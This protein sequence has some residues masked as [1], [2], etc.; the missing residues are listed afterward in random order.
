MVRVALL[1][2]GAIVSV[3]YAAP[4]DLQE[5]TPGHPPGQKDVVSPFGVTTTVP[6]SMRLTTP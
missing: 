2:I 1:V 6:V 5:R 4:I 3:A